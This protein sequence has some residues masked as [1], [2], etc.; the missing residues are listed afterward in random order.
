MICVGLYIIILLSF[1]IPCRTNLI[2][3]LHQINPEPFCF[4]CFYF[5]WIKKNQ[6]KSVRRICHPM[7]KQHRALPQV[8]FE[9]WWVNHHRDKEFGIQSSRWSAPNIAKMFCIALACGTKVLY[10]FPYLT[11][12]KNKMFH[13]KKNNNETIP[14]LKASVFVHSK[15]SSNDPGKKYLQTSVEPYHLNTGD[16]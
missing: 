6:E 11:L 14:H 7:P 13:L 8:E 16:T 10:L 9:I 12:F 1:I 3:W 2:C 15:L 5:F 4:F